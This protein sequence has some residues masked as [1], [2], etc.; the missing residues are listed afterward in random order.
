MRGDDDDETARGLRILLIDDDD[1][2]VRVL[3]RALGSRHSVS[4]TGSIARAFELLRTEEFDAV[5]SDWDLKQEHD[6]LAVRREARVRLPDAQRIL[7]PGNEGD[8]PSSDALFDHYRRKPFASSAL[9]AVRCSAR[10]RGPIG[11][12]G[13]GEERVEAAGL[14][15]R[16]ELRVAAHR[17]PVD[18]DLRDGALTGGADEPLAQ[19]VAIVA[20]DLFE[21]GAFLFKEALGGAAIRAITRGVDGHFG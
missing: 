12:R 10:Q 6:G 9:L 18:E 8:P 2:V 15:Q 16:G 14:L 11:R 5:V 7:L 21:W 13:G 1:L 19:I 4:T 20:A 17:L 3:R